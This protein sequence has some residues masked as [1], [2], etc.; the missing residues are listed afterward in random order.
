MTRPSLSGSGWLSVASNYKTRAC[1]V[2]LAAKT[3]LI[4]LIALS[5]MQRVNVCQ[6]IR[7]YATPTARLEALKE[8]LAGRY[9]LNY[10]TQHINHVV[11]N[12]P[13]S[14]Q[15]IPIKQSKRAV[16]GSF[17]PFQCQVWPPPTPTPKQEQ[18]RPL[19]PF[20]AMLSALNLPLANGSSPPFI[21]LPLPNWLN[22]ARMRSQAREVPSS[23]WQRY[24][25]RRTARCYL[26]SARNQTK[27]A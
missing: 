15:N 24:A 1:A 10:M 12:T 11:C 17:A 18:K 20:G 21:R 23:V 5:Y 4:D 8:A 2:R 25:S 27:P 16:E 26:T 13:I 22:G 14:L 6:L 19:V 3:P 9:D 7:R